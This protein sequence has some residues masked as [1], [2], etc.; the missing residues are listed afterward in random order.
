VEAEADEELQ[1]TLE[2][3]DDAVNYADWIVHLLGPYLD[4]RILEIGAGHGTMSERLARFGPLTASEPS[5]SAHAVLNSRFDLD[6]GISV[7]RADALGAVDGR[8][9][10]AIVMINVLEHIEDDAGTV[11]AL[12]GSLNPQGHLVLYVPAFPLLYSKFDRRIGH[13]RRYRRR[14]LVRLLRDAGLELVE[15][16]YVNL[17][18]AILWF[19]SARL[20]RMTP[21]RRWSAI[22]YDRV[23]VPVVR[24]VEAVLPIPFGQSLLCVGR[25][26]DPALGR[27]DA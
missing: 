10:D 23:A 25:R 3:L 13:H 21:T 8:S 7:L 9:F 12:A 6:D 20:L 16:R 1:E 27:I 22:L 11:K 4:G 26:S 14:G 2:S 17:P 19:L 24:R 15:T 18:G 5:E